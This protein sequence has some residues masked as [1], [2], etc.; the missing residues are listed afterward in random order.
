MKVMILGAN[1]FL[2][3]HLYNYLK[4]KNN[5]IKCGRNKNH[6]IVLKKIVKSNFSKILKKTIP[7]VI[8]NL[9]ALTNVDICEKKRK[10][11]DEINAGIVKNIVDSITEV[12]LTKKVF[13]LHI[14][15]D[16]V[17]SGKGPH[18]EKFIRPINI[19]AR[20]KLKGEKYIK[21]ING[22]VLRTNFVGKSF[23]NKERGFTD[24]IF[25]SLNQG[26]SIPVFKNV[27]FSP[28]NIK[29]L[30]KYINLVIRKK[31]AGI[32]NLGSKN[33]LSKAQFAIK[34]A[35]KLKLN[36]KLLKVV[37]YK[38]DLLI[39]KRPLDMRMNIN[40]FEK[41]FHV[42]LKSLNNEINLVS[43]QYKVIR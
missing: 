35:K 15:T 9:I 17:Y 28:L 32:Y 43:R 26:K 24:W 29:T 16:Q 30:C 4:E 38:K 12:K 14:S 7:D 1:G 27:K 8:I 42:R 39:A 34:F 13:F 11:A 21:K 10:K 22:C 6:D 33:G 40:L 31:I 41:N 18:K 20:T 25:T 2:G 5:I 23:D 37:D 19:Y 36:T 3:S